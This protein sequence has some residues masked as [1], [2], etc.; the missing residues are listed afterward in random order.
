LAGFRIPTAAELDAERISWS[1]SNSA[2]AFA[3]SSKL[4]LG[5]FRSSGGVLSAVGSGGNYWSSTISGTDSRDLAILTSTA[6]MDDTHRVYGFSV[7]CIQETIIPDGTVYNSNT[8]KFW[9]D[10]N[11]GA[12]QVATS[13]TDETS[14]GD[15]YQWGR[16]ADGHQLRSSGTTTIISDS[17]TPGHADFIIGDGDWRWPHNDDLWQGVNGVN[18]PC[19]DGF[20][21]PTIAELNAERLT[22]STKNA[23][24]AFASPLKLPVA[25]YRSYTDGSL[26]SVSSGGGYWSSTVSGISTSHLDFS[27]SSASTSVVPRGFGFSVRCIKD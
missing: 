22:W 6:S 20:R 25:G 7:R 13:S 16:G 2:G 18:N 12:S 14:Y 15:L 11:L 17:D 19:P 8:G 26:I 21:I 10:R 5:G 24:G 9:M 4:T 23:A 3:S 1:S 27:S